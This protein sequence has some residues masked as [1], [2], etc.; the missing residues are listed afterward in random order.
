MQKTVKA[1]I[2]LT[3]SLLVFLTFVYSAL[4][5]Q[6]E[7]SQV[8]LFAMF[9]IFLALLSYILFRGHERVPGHDQK[10]IQQKLSAMHELNMK[11]ITFLDEEKIIRA[12][13]ETA[14]K[15]LDFEFCD[16]LLVDRETNEL[17]VMDS[18]GE[19]ATPKGYRVPLD[20]EKGISAAVVQ[21]EKAIHLAD[22]SK[23]R[24]YISVR[25]KEGS[26]L[27]VP[28]TVKGKVIGVINAEK[29]E[30]NA[31]SAV[32]E[33]LF[34][35]LATQVAIA[36][37]N[38]RLNK[39]IVESEKRYRTVINNINVGVSLISPR[40]EI[41]FLNN[42]MKK[43]FPHID[44]AERPLCYKAFNAPPR[45]EVCSYCPTCKT[46]QD[47]SIHDSLTDTPVNGQ[48]INYWVTSFPVKD[49]QGNVIAAIELI[50]DVT[51]RKRHEK[52]II[53]AK[54]EWENTFDSVPDLIVIVDSDYRIMR[55]NK[56]MAARLG[57]KPGEA[58]GKPCH[59][60]IHGTRKPPESCLLSRSKDFETPGSDEFHL[61]TLGGDFLV[62]VSPL[63]KDGGKATGAVHV[64]RDITERKKME[65]ALA[66]SEEKYRATAEESQTGVY[67][68]QDGVFAFVNKRLCELIGY[69]YDEVVNKLSPYDLTHPDDHEIVRQKIEE[70]M[71]RDIRTAEYEIRA[72]RKDGTVFPVRLL[73]SIATYRGKPAIIGTL[74]DLSKEKNLELNLIRAQKMESL[75]QLAGG[76]AHDFNNVLGIIMGA[77]DLL[78]NASLDERSKKLLDM[79]I[80]ASAR[81]SEIVKRL[82]LFARAEETALIPVSL[83]EIIDETIGILEHSIE[84]NISISKSIDE[85]GDVILGNKEQLTQMILNICMNA[86]DAMPSGGTLSI[87]L[88]SEG[89]E[90]LEDYYPTARDQSF[91]IISISD[92]GTGMDDSTKEKIFDP[93]FTTKERGKG[94]GL[95]LAIVHSIIKNHKGFIDV[96]SASGKGT[97]FSI[98]LPAETSPVTET[99]SLERNLPSLKRA[100]NETIMIVDDEE[101]IRDLLKE[102]LEPLGYTMIE[103]ADGTEAIERYRERSHTIDLV[104]LDIGLPGMTGDQVLSELRRIDPGSSVIVASGYLDA[105]R[106]AEL[107]RLGVT[108]FIQKPYTLKELGSAIRQT[109]DDALAK[110]H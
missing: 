24:R 53:H 30:L 47:G 18:I 104:I 36:I 100:N 61:E 5:L 83:R 49:D 11:M 51:E 59:M 7:S 69:T 14:V 34:S 76:I 55:L 45:E 62:T 105:P 57:M 1:S 17:V 27:C 110:V 108:T 42:Q 81:G 2:I 88:G 87:H 40:M 19:M 35:E 89:A 46:L 107:E 96:R 16:F 22:V 44:V 75:G 97:T 109:L 78:Q 12:T 101:P 56:A 38:A 25:F 98:Y 85:S 84:K 21:Q 68:I 39:T 23:D 64:F 26:E 10:Q 58:I 28:I 15:I 54:E 13:L 31:F 80:H 90:D 6:E 43:W 37:E 99:D 73:G 63:I 102:L 41:L 92:T 106:K 77:L 72:L 9:A 86:R 52:M 3:A 65:Q 4:A 66:E 74:L 94:T 93:F 20:N 79:S 8:L 71:R 91:R 60:L 95:G 50:E 67:I 82:L 32:D 48:I 29:K 33:I 70:R 103:A